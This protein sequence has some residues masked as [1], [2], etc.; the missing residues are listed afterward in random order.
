MQES[1]FSMIS[2]SRMLAIALTHEKVDV[3]NIHKHSF[4]QLYC[5]QQ[6]LMVI[7]S[8]TGVIVTPPHCVGWIPSFCEHSILANK[9]I[10]GWTVLLDEKCAEQFSKYPTLLTC[11]FLMEP[12]IQRMAGWQVADTECMEYQHLADVFLD[13]L[14]MANPMPLSLPI[15]QDPRLKKI[16]VYLLE[17]PQS[18]QKLDDLAHG[19]GLSARSLSRHWSVEV[20]MSIKKYRQMAKLFKSLD[21]IV[22]G[23]SIEQCAWM[24]GFESTSAYILAF[25][26]VFK[27]TPKEYQSLLN[28]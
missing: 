10:S 1:D 24:C 3:T 11:S 2:K 20:G 6:G 14:K 8:E 7:R 25:K 26:T 28:G 9:K 12:L 21:D 23:R 15:P 19:V 16:A 17:N 4:A 22:A 5:L 27:S 18:E 13:E